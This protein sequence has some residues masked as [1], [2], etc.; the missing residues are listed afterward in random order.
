MNVANHGVYFTSILAVNI[1]MILSIF[2][3]DGICNTSTS[4]WVVLGGVGGAGGVGGR[5]IDI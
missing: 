4:S 3:H 5:V 2:F 1:T